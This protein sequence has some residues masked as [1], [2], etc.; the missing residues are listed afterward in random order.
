MPLRTTIT[1]LAL[2]VS[3]TASAQNTWDFRYRLEARASYRDSNHE[4]FLLRFPLPPEFLPVGQTSAFL[5]TVDPGQHAELNLATVQLDARY[6]TWFQARAKVHAV[7]KYRRNPTS[8]DRTSDI[9]ELFLVIGDMPEFLERPDGTSLFLLVGKA[10]RME[11]QPLRLLESYGL[12]AT[13]FNRFEDVQAIAGG[14]L[15]RNFYWR[16]QAGNGNPLYFRD[17]NA[18]AGD[19][20]VPALREPNP[21]PELHSGF[22]ILYNAETEDLSFNG[23]NTQLGQALGYRWANDA[24]SV[25]FDLIVFHYQRDLADTVGLT[26]TFYGGDLDLLDGPFNAG[27]GGIPLTGRNKEE[28]GAR[29]YSELLGLTT[30]AQFTAQEIAG[31]HRQA[32][33][34]ETGYRFALPWA[35]V[36]FIQPAVRL[37]DLQNSFSGN[38]ALHP[39]P[40]LW[41]DWEKLDIG[42][43]IG[44]AH[45]V[46]LTIERST[47]EVEA[48]RE[49]DLDE[50][51]ATIRWRM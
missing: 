16:V 15:G 27:F 20:G 4:R 44:F 22:P 24:Q 6:G 29:L 28:S 25:G 12:A 35:A 37:S 32:W 13:S 1:L 43:R 49:L 48:P 9:D 7:D 11:R 17:A 5:E 30:I 36:Q 46:D 21:D 47:H 51:L 8:N 41:W 19:N 33:E 50:T 38:A 39:A 2:S 14:T 3:L 10:P 23:E 45:N 31:L 26:G 18:L 34:I 42:V 40:S